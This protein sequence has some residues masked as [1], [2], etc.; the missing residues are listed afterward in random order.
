MSAARKAI[1]EA[2]NEDMR[3]GDTEGFLSRVPEDFVWTMVGEAPIRGKD[4]IR[5]W[6]A[7]VGPQ[8]PPDFTVRTVVADG[9]VVAAMG[10]MTMPEN[11]V[12][13]AHISGTCKCVGYDRGTVSP[14]EVMEATA[15]FR[16][17]TVD[18]AA[19]GAS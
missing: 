16:V 6:M 7:G 4:A 8:E 17:V 9:D 5:Q 11:G 12:P 13:V 18:T 2:I 19:A 15:T 1:V 14:D 10:V 3:R